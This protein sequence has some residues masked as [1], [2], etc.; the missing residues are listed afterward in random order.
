MK[1]R[2][3]EAK[4][5]AASPQRAVIFPD[6][7]TV[8]T[9]PLRPYSRDASFQWLFSV[10]SRCAMP[11]VAPT[12]T[13][14]LNAPFSIRT[15]SVLWPFDATRFMLSYKG[16]NAL[17]SLRSLPPW[18][19]SATNPRIH[20][21]STWPLY[22]LRTGCSATASYLPLRSIFTYPQVYTNLPITF[23]V[24][25]YTR[26]GMQCDFRLVDQ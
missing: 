5:T 24:G 18:P 13:C 25:T 20:A 2:P 15:S 11:S 26:G 8:Y 19:V 1:Y 6:G 3:S 16:S 14:N 17:L 21:S 10:S 12:P 4:A 7:S 9:M 22:P 23:Q